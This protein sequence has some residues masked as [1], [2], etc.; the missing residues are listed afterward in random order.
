VQYVSSI[1]PQLKTSQDI[2]FPVL[3]EV[4]WAIGKQRWEPSLK[5]IRELQK[6]I[7]VIFDN[8]QAMTDLREATSWTYKQIDLDGHLS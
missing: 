3:T 6:K 4:V 1:L 5:P 8:S 7:W 2:N